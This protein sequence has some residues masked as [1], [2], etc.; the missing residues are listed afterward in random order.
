[1]HDHGVVR[2]EGQQD[3]RE[4]IDEVERI[5]AQHLAPREGGVGQR[6][7][8]V[9]DRAD[10]KLAADRGHRAHRRMQ[11]RREQKRDAGAA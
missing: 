3:S 11:L 1:M 2:A 10:A 8:D 7:E 9:E 5:D 6:P 4:K